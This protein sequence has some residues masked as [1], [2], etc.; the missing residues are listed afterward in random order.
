MFFSKDTSHV[1]IFLAGLPPII[2]LF[3]KNDLVT[4]LPAATTILST[5]VTPGN[6]TVFAPTKQLSPILI[7]PKVSVTPP[8]H[9]NNTVVVC[10]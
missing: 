9:F 8:R 7:A 1:V 3:S 5:K 4:T 10:K 2:M 6:I